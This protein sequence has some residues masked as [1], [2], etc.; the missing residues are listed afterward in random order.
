MTKWL[1]SP[2]LNPIEPKCVHGKRKVSEADRILSV[3]ELEA[4]VCAS[5]G[6]PREPHLVMPQKVA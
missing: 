6:Y 2:W 5:Y 4:R 3:D 1:K